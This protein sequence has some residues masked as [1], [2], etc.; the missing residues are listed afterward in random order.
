MSGVGTLA[1]VPLF[2]YSFYIAESFYACAFIMISNNFL[3]VWY[4][5]TYTMINRIFPSNL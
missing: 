1:V 3:G 2:L 5:P 4:G